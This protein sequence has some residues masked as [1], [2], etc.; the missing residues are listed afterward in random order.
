M[1]A[2]CRIRHSDPILLVLSTSLLSA[3]LP[4]TASTGLSHHS[5]LSIPNQNLRLDSI[6]GET[7][8]QESGE[9][10]IT[11]RRTSCSFLKGVREKERFWL[12]ERRKM[13]WR[14]DTTQQWGPMQLHG[15]TLSLGKSEWNQMRSKMQCIIHCMIRCYEIRYNMWCKLS[16][17]G[18][19]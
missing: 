9:P 8:D 11:L 16:T 15:S 12:E 5:V 3:Y 13:A 17:P 7:T 18:P 4:I 14:Y 10:I 1:Y 6:C 2:P 19:P